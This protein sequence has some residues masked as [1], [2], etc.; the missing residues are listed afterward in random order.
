MEKSNFF[1]QIA[2]MSFINRWALM[3]NVK[4]ENLAE[5]SFQVAV[6]AHMLAL[7]ENKYCGKNIDVGNVAVVALYHDAAEIFTGDL[8]TPVKYFNDDIAKAYK[9][10]EHLAEDK[11]VDF[12]PREFVDD[13]RPLISSKAVDP[14]V[15]RIVKDADTICAIIKCDHELKAN[16]HEFAAAKKRLEQQLRSRKENSPGIKYF[17][18]MFMDSFTKT[19]DEIS[20]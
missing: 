5:H 9:H 20:V 14:E 4:N 19:L 10:L 2:R 17:E 3:R 18:E 16:N 6:V 11:L 12:M 8:P 7:I 1:A 13:F 15:K